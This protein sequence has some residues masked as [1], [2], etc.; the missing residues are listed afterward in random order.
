MLIQASPPVVNL[1]AHHLA[2][3]PAA[4]GVFQ[5]VRG[6]QA[7]QALGTVGKLDPIPLHQV[8]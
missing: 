1:G 6:P 4:D 7:R 8:M 2:N 5:K 3:R